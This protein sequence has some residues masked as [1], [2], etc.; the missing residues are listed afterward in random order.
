MFSG[1]TESRFPCRVDMFEVAVRA[2]DTH[3]VQRE[4]DKLAQI[5]FGSRIKRYWRAHSSPEQEGTK[6]RR[7]PHFGTKPETAQPGGFLP[8]AA[9]DRAVDRCFRRK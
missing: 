2:G 4:V 6:S 7:G 5:A 3:E 8:V 1:E 9:I